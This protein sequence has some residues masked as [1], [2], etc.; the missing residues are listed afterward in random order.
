[1]FKEDDKLIEIYSDGR[2]VDGGKEWTFWKYTKHN[3]VMLK[4]F[5]DEERYMFHPDYFRKLTKLDKA[6]K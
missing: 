1:M 6:L 2:P 3:R 4:N 5:P